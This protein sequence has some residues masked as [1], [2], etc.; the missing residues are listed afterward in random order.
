MR[1]SDEASCLLGAGTSLAALTLEAPG[2][3][4]SVIEV[5]KTNLML[6]FLNLDEPP[7]STHW[8]N[9]SNC[10]SYGLEAIAKL[11]LDRMSIR[12]SDEEER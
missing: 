10:V 4:L 5:S 12:W 7:L 3:L 1:S 11:T 2:A 6:C 8:N 9:V